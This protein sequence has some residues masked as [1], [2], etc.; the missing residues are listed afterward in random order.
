MSRKVSADQLFP[1]IIPATTDF[2]IEITEAV[3][4]KLAVDYD[5]PVEYV[6]RCMKEHAVTHLPK[7]RMPDDGYGPFFS[8]MTAHF[9]LDPSLTKQEFTAECDINNI[10]RR[11]TQSGYDPST[12][13]LTTRK[14]QYGDFSNMPQSYHEALN[15]VKD[16]ERA[17][18]TLDADLRARFENDPQQFLDFV[19]NPDN[20]EELVKLGLATAPNIEAQTLSPAPGAATS[21]E[22]EGAGGKSSKGPKP[23]VRA[24]IEPQGGSGGE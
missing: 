6:R 20:A 1:A 21:G 17:F 9:N 13:P 10:M 4:E 7:F 8:D 16:T 18:M 19:S 3:I 2:L 15:Y 14:P 24:P 12:L 23:S 22:A 5:K 11:F